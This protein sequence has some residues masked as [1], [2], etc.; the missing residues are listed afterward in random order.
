MSDG[1]ALNNNAT[2]NMT[3]VPT[4]IGYSIWKPGVVLL[5]KNFLLKIAKSD[6]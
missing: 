6:Y 2:S 5:Y 3:S 4:G 1:S